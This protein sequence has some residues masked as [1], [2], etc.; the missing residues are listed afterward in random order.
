[1]FATVRVAILAPLLAALAAPVLA[2]GVYTCTDAKGRHLTADRP[3]LEC[4]DREQVEL[5][6]GGVRRRI[7]PSLTAAERAAEEEKVRRLEED[8]SRQA[9]ER[10]REK[11]L[12]TRYPNRAVHDKE[13]AEA[14]TM[15]DSVTA[16][17]LVRTRELQVQRKYLDGEV[18]FYKINPSRTPPKL[19]RQIEDVDKQLDAQRR[20][21]ASQE[22]EKV[23]VNAR[24]DEELSRLKLLWAQQQ[25]AAAASAAAPV[26]TTVAR[27]ASASRPASSSATR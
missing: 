3:I 8:R 12:L 10:K 18:E 7:G 11:A 24:F 27:A 16:A 23:R 15:V 26:P 22:V 17:A 9:E 20:F 5:S 4:I 13:R 25:G 14:L 21:V 6:S 1:M 2:E 19:K